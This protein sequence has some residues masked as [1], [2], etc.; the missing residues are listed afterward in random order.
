MKSSLFLS[1]PVRWVLALVIGG[2]GFTFMMVAH[3]TFKRIGTN[4]ATHQ[5][6]TTFVVQGAY[7]FSRNPM[8]LGG[9]VWFFGIGLLAGS[10]WMLAA[11]IPLGLYLSFYVIPREEAY[12]ERAFGDGSDHGGKVKKTYGRT[13][14]SRSVSG[15]LCAAWGVVQIGGHCAHPGRNEYIET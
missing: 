13:D 14:A 10:L 8:Y 2:S 1:S 12:M 6:A 9:S 15:T 7:R 5:P 11:Y 4:I 3:E